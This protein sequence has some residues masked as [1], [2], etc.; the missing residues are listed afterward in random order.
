[1]VIGNLFPSLALLEYQLT[2]LLEGIVTVT[3]F[4]DDGSTVVVYSTV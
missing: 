1:M 4:D 3:V 2:W